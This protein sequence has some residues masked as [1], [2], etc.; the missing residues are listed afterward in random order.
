MAYNMRRHNIF[1]YSNPRRKFRSFLDISGCDI[2]GSDV[3]FVREK[4]GGKTIGFEVEFDLVRFRREGH[5]VCSGI[6]NGRSIQF[7]LSSLY[8]QGRRVLDKYELEHGLESVS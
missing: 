2:I 8:E 7:E 1:K 4:N 5:L 6:C 3:M